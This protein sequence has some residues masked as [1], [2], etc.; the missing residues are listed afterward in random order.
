M[1]LYQSLSDRLKNQHEAIS[2]I[3]EELPQDRIT[4]RPPDD[5]WSIHEHITHLASY[6]PVFMERIHRILNEDEPFFE[7]YEAQND[8]G[9]EQWL[10]LDTAE[11]LKR[12]D[13]YRAQMFDQVIKLSYA[14]QNR[15]GVHKK[16]GRLTVVEWVEFFLL[17][18][19]HHMFVVFQLAKTT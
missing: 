3:L 2:H 7:R 8:P 15:I 19:A 4:S 10:Q 13:G 12:M 5:K 9:F 14:E 6:Q 1:S 16:F 18:E 17:H 11:V